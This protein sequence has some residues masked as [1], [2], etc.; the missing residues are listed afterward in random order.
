ML[1]C[2]PHR[3]TYIHIRLAALF[4]RALH[5][6]ITYQV[7]DKFLN[8]PQYPF[9]AL[10]LLAESAR[11]MPGSSASSTYYNIRLRRLLLVAS[12]S[13]KIEMA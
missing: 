8:S 3:S 10:S 9:R 7:R 6:S 2:K 5:L 1:L 11:R 4:L 13:G 12:L